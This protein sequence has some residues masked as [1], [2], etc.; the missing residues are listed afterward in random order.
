MQFATLITWLLMSVIARIIGLC[1]NEGRPG[2]RPTHTSL[3]LEEL[4]NRLTPAVNLTVGGNVNVSHLA[5]NQAEETIAINPLNPKD[6]FVAS[7]DLS[8]ATKTPSAGLFVRYSTDGGTTWTLPKVP[9][10]ANGKDNFP[11]ACCD[12]K[13]AYD[14]FGNLFLTYLSNSLL[15]EKGKSTQALSNATYPN[16]QVRGVLVDASKKGKNA[17]IPNQWAGYRLTVKTTTG[18]V[19]SNLIIAN[20]ENQLIL[21]DSW[22]FNFDK[23]SEAAEYK[24]ENRGIVVLTSSDDGKNFSPVDTGLKLQTSVPL[25]RGV[26]GAGADTDRPAIATGPSGNKQSPGSVWVGWFNRNYVFDPTTGELSFQVA[27]FTSGEL[28]TKLATMRPLALQ[29]QRLPTTNYFRRV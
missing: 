4:E 12:P 7:N 10:I 20:T 2:K 25:P 21:Q 18:R 22:D 14:Q 9:E 28:V 11:P 16:K 3:V 13:A 6:I 19:V 8:T 15:W 26:I 27:Y 1:G 29:C 23:F 24:I 17:W 5:G